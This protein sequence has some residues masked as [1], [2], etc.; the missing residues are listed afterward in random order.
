MGYLFILGRNLELSIAEIENYLISKNNLI[1]SKR[2]IQ[3]NLFLEL[4]NKLDDNAI[5]ELGG[6]VSI[7]EVLVKG[8]KENIINNLE[9]KEI[10]FGT[11]NNISYCIWEFS[12]HSKIIKEYLKKRFKK[13]KLKACIKKLNDEIAHQSGE[14]SYKP[15][16]KSLD[17]EYFVFDFDKQIYF[18]RII[19]KCDYK[20][21]EERD[22]K[23]PVRREK[24]AISPRIAKIMINLSQIRENEILIDP[25]CGIGIILEESLQRNIKVVGIDIDKNA[26]KDAEKNLKWF[27][28]SS[29]NYQLINLD[30]RKVK[31]PYAKTIVTEPNLGDI[32][33]NEPSVEKANEMMKEFE[34]LMIEVLNNLKKNIY[35]RIVFSSPLIKLKN[36]RISCN[37]EKI[38]TKTNLKLVFEP[39]DEY[40]EEQIIGRR[41]FVLEK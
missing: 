27:G 35:G 17:E 28:F 29:K 14:I 37:I 16:S 41:I 31:I 6:T 23:K 2:N 33:K 36:Q 9:E 15:S 8:N 7:G 3:S 26:I 5:N 32:L 22:M 38:L 39:F 13:E 24:L 21:L 4:K 18:G 10:Y 1:I 25:F 34:V 19:Q 40:R 20:K 12:N 11:K 30:S